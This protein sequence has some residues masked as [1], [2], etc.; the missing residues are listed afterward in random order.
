MTFW[1]MIK[2]MIHSL[3]SKSFN[4][5]DSHELNDFLRICHAL[6]TLISFFRKSRSLHFNWFRMIVIVLRLSI[7]N[8]LIFFN[9]DDTTRE[10]WN[11]LRS[12]FRRSELLSLR[13]RRFRRNVKNSWKSIDFSFRFVMFNIR[14]N[15][16]ITLFRIK[17]SF[18]CFLS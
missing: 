18:W 12:K 7:L 5:F 6:M 3:M 13:T 14:K 15:L 8:F 2:M 1:L 4:T 16:S 10:R 9:V 17:K 11:A